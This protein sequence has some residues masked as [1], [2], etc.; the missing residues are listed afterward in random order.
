MRPAL[1]TAAL[2][3]REGVCVKAILARKEVTSERTAPALSF[4]IIQDALPW[5]V[6][7]IILGRGSKL[8]GTRLRPELPP[9][10]DQLFLWRIFHGSDGS[11]YSSVR[12]VGRS[13]SGE[14]ETGTPNS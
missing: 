10:L 1:H 2:L 5:L 4:K 13:S 6:A 7:L 12:P 11:L 14:I 3:T 8:L 9:R